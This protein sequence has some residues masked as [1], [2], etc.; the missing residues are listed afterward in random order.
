MKKSRLDSVLLWGVVLNCS[1][2][3][4]SSDGSQLQ[5]TQGPAV[6][7]NAAALRLEDESVIMQSR[8]HGQM[9]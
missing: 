2:C 9:R 5:P 3:G 7:D 4:A 8:M 6:S 1:Q